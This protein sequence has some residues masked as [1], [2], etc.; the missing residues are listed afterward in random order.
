MQRDISTSHGIIG[1]LVGCLTLKH[2]NSELKF[3]K[4]AMT[5]TEEQ[6]TSVEVYFSANS[7]R[8]VEV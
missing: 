8:S 2:G 5:E 6:W 7:E 3:Q 1:T 4:I